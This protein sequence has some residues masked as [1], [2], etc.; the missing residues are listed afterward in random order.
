MPDRLE[1]DMDWTEIYKR[2]CIFAEEPL[3][4]VH[5]PVKYKRIPNS[6]KALCYYEMGEP[7]FSTSCSVYLVPPYGKRYFWSIWQSFYN[8]I[9]PF[10]AR[11]MAAI[12][13]GWVRAEPDDDPNEIGKFLLI[14]SFAADA[15]E[16]PGKPSKNMP[17]DINEIGSGILTRHDT[18]ACI[19]S[20][21]KGFETTFKETDP[22]IKKNEVQKIIDASF[23]VYKPLVK[24]RLNEY[25]DKD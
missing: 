19:L 14:G 4:G 21:Y 6:K 22:K 11:R 2:D 18:I 17:T 9:A 15:M 13:M 23:K 24:V 7:S 20:I 8:P 10:T 25:I 16:Q 12:P 5:L 1:V 3:S